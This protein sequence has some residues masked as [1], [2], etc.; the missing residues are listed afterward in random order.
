M[1]GPSFKFRA[2]PIHL[3]ENENSREAL[4]RSSSAQTDTD[5]YSRGLPMRTAIVHG[6]LACLSTLGIASLVWGYLIS[7]PDSAIQRASGDFAIVV[8]L[9]SISIAWS[10]LHTLFFGTVSKDFLELASTAE[11]ILII[12]SL[13]FYPTVCGY[14]LKISGI[15]ETC[16]Y[17]TISGL[18]VAYMVAFIR[19]IQL[20]GRI[21]TPVIQLK[22]AKY[23]SLRLGPESHTKTHSACVGFYTISACLSILSLGMMAWVYYMLVNIARKDSGQNI[24]QAIHGFAGSSVQTMLLL[25]ALLWVFSNG[26]SVVMFGRVFSSRISSLL[27]L[28]LAVGLMGVSVHGFMWSA[29]LNIACPPEA[30]CPRAWMQIRSHHFAATLLAFVVGLVHLALFVIRLY[31][32]LQ[33]M[34]DSFLLHRLNSPSGL[35]FLQHR[36]WT[37]DEIILFLKLNGL[38]EEARDNI[39]SILYQVHNEDMLPDDDEKPPSME[40]PSSRDGAQ[41]MADEKQR[42]EEQLCLLYDTRQVPMDEECGLV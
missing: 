19:L 28:A 15:V 5:I 12:S 31:P 2:G 9:L 17:I 14:E 6:S 23:R 4:V 39:V 21:I 36:S 10:G 25:V 37:D 22:N 42:R 13:I 3:G 20:L 16:D 35:S 7:S 30:N 1:A 41:E 29:Q 38:T 40:S 33:S 32:N 8:V 18:A 27:E 26:Y 34:R 11:D 24:L